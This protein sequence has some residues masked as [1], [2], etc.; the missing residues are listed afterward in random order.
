[1]IQGHRSTGRMYSIPL[2]MAG[3]PL[4]LRTD[5]TAVVEIARGFFP[6]TG[7]SKARQARADLSL[8][9]GN[10]RDISSA[11]CGFPIFRGR[12]QY[13][14]A[15]YG[16]D[17]SVWFDLKA[18][19]VSGIVSEGLIA[20]AELFRRNVLSVIAGVL[21]PSIGLIGLHAGCVVRDGKAV[22]LA[23]SS[24]VGKSTLTLALALRGWSLLSDDWT[25]LAGEPTGLSVWGMLTALK[26]LPDAV[27]YYPSLA[28]LC[29]APA[30][31]GEMSFE[32]D[33]WRFFG[34]DRAIDATP[35][36]I[37]L[38][39]RS[40]NAYG[41]CRVHLS[42][43]DSEEMQAALFKEIEELP[44]GINQGDDHRLSVIK[45]V[46]AL[47]GFKVRMNGHPETIAA[48]L[49]PL[50]SEYVCG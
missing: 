27:R 47:P 25:F 45:R 34:V 41:D 33:P 18:R 50:L 7:L 8:F 49:D 9:V 13:V 6:P 26:L 35:V 31:N 11:K 32:V 21:A 48:D 4:H 24:G 28:V 37:I 12:N 36:S 10:R 44:A 1:M 42:R 14:H 43:C 3:C 39:E 2:G 16:S 20:D 40:Q 38:L 46:C 23:A 22:L 19:A 30:L 17:G 29:P 5:S 15:D